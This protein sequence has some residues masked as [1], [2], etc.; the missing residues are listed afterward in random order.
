[1]QSLSYNRIQAPKKTVNDYLQ[2]LSNEELFSIYGTSFQY[3][4]QLPD[5]LKKLRTEIMRREIVSP[6]KLS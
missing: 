1:M 3:N 4:I 2:Q 5:L 6:F